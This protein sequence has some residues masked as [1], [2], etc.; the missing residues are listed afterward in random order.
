M[1]LSIIMAPVQVHCLTETPTHIL[2]H[3]ARTSLSIIMAPAQVH[4][5]TETP[6]NM[7]YH[8]THSTFYNYGTCSGALSHINILHHMARTALNYGT[9]SGARRGLESQRHSVRL[10]T[11]TCLYCY[12]TFFFLFV[13]F[14]SSAKEWCGLGCGQRFD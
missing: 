10:C 14:I 1:T 8:G 5:L 13:H 2:H 6:T 11:K 3:M 12:K 7:L 4:C 9:S